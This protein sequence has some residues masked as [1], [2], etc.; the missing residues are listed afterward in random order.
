MQNYFRMKDITKEFEAQGMLEKLEEA[1]E[2]N[3]RR[4]SS[5]TQN[6]VGWLCCVR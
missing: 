4:I 2:E 5:E 3:G 1:L 6:G